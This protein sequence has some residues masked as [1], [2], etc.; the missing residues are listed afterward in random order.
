ML[1]CFLYFQRFEV[2][3]K[4][5][6]SSLSKVLIFVIKNLCTYASDF[7]DLPSLLLTFHFNINVFNESHICTELA[8]HFQSTKFDKTSDLEFRNPPGQMPTQQY[9]DQHLHSLTFDPHFVGTWRK[10]LELH[11]SSA[12]IELHIS[13]SP[14]R[15]SFFSI[16]CQFRSIC[17]VPKSKK[18]KNNPTIEFGCRK[19]PQIKSCGWGSL[20]WSISDCG[21]R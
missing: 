16:F 8:S 15:F 5:M 12:T 7:T 9:D 13:L 3:I 21:C 6:H 2:Y 1:S 14:A 17:G 4:Y 19:W 10:V 18:T 20:I 11:F